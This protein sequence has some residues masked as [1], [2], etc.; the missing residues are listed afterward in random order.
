MGSIVGTVQL[1]S[2]KKGEY[3]HKF[4]FINMLP[5]SAVL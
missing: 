4:I 3:D 2:L 5:L 1:T